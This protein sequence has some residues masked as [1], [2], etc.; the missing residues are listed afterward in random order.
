MKTDPYCLPPGAERLVYDGRALDNE[1]EARQSAL[2]CLSTLECTYCDVC[3]WVCPDMCITRDPDT[4]HINIDLE[5]CKGCGLCAHFCPKGA[6]S[7][8]VELG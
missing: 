7:M 6:I 5:Y 4:G 8:E 1:A 3:Q 2:R